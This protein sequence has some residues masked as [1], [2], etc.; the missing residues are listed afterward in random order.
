VRDLLAELAEASAARA[1]GR[2]AAAAA[3]ARRALAVYRGELLPEDGPAEWVV[4]ERDRLR[5]HVAT[6][7][8]ELAEDCLRLGEVREGL[9]AARR[10]LEL[11]R[12]QD[13]VW[14]LL[15]EL[16]ERAGDRAAAARARQEHAEALAE[17]TVPGLGRTGAGDDRPVSLPRQ[18]GPP[19][20][21]GRGPA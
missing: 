4:P 9:D 2:R 11:D 19:R 20:G 5:R 16:H 12:Y 8:G 7:A 14:E 1:R 21:A 17:L 6:A 13:R 10:A 18:G 3:A 15:S